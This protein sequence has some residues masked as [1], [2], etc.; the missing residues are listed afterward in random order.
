MRKKTR[1]FWA[2]ILIILIML[3]FISAIYMNWENISKQIIQQDYTGKVFEETV[4]ET[5]IAE[6]KDEYTKSEFEKGN[7]RYD[8]LNDIELG[9]TLWYDKNENSE[10]TTFSITIDKSKYSNLEIQIN[11]LVEKI[12][13]KV[14]I[15]NSDELLLEIKNIKENDKDF[16]ALGNQYTIYDNINSNIQVAVYSGEYNIQID[17]KIKEEID[18]NKEKLT[19]DVLLINKENPFPENYQ[20]E[21]VKYN[22]IDINLKMQT[23]LDDMLVEAEKDGITLIMNNAYRSIQDQQELYDKRI[24]EFIAQG[25]TQEE[26]IELTEDYVTIPGY[27]EHHTGLAID[28][29]GANNEK[30]WSWLQQ[31]AHE[32]GFILRYPDDKYMITQ[33]NN[34]PWHYYYVGK[35]IATYIYYSDLVLEEYVNIT[36]KD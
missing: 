23:S 33:I 9:L 10:I 27:S 1:N 2:N 6:T 24:A 32:F 5:A 26:A 35:D 31:N 4:I 36:I 29:S 25:Y 11:N 16:F 7:V 34:E 18:I 3:L 8:Y 14:Y 21:L 13:E 17:Y 12:N 20:F 19:D 15:N 28:F 30:M 22:K